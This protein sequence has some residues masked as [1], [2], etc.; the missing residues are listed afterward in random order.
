MAQITLGG[1]PIH[2]AG[3]IPAKGDKAA[4]FSLVS[5]EFKE[6]KLSD[7]SGKKVV[8]NIF[9]SID[10]SVCA[11]SVRKFNET[12]AKK[13]NTVVLNISKDLPFAHR[14]FCA[15]E[16][17]EGV[18]ALSEFKDNNFSDS[19]NV[20][21]TDGGMAGLM[22][23]VVIVVDADGTVAHSEQVPEIGQEPNYDAAL[24]AL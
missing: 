4:D 16:G 21:M 11:T 5:N 19:Y 18:Y 10:T 17:L 23:R 15:A 20:K 13:D 14:R 22:S 24:A 6:V 3:T 7:F 8:L 9:P 2:T 12:A 1:N